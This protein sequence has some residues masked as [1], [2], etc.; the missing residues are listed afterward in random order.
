[1][2]WE[3]EDFNLLVKKTGNQLSLAMVSRLYIRCTS[4]RV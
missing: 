3:M 2:P 1:M 4:V